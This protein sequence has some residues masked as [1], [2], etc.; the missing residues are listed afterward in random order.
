[1]LRKSFCL[2]LVAMTAGCTNAGVRN[3][4]DFATS[5]NELTKREVLF[6]LRKAYDEQATFVPSHVVVSQGKSTTSGS[7]SP[8]FT[9]PLGPGYSNTI[10]PSGNN[11]YTGVT[12]FGAGAFTI[13]GNATAS[14]DWT[15]T[16]ATDSDALMR[17]RTLYLYVAGLINSEDE[18]LCSYPVQRQPV[19]G[20]DEAGKGS[21][22]AYR[23]DCP[24]RPESILFYADPN[25]VTY[26]NCIVCITSVGLAARKHRVKD[27]AKPP[28]AEAEV[29]APDEVRAR[30]RVNDRLQRGIVFG[31]T[32]RGDVLGSEPRKK[33]QEG[34]TDLSRALTAAASAQDVIPELPLPQFSLQ[35]STRVYLKVGT[36]KYFAEFILLT[37]AAMA[38][39]TP[40][41]EK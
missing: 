11:Q 36:E 38:P 39:V 9:L 3:S 2:F 1:M 5:L 20:L 19:T 31:V 30:V 23:L 12:T 14:Q 16:P 25:F 32:Y 4:A 6:N 26:P 10:V 41:K 18:F 35:R 34:D 33:P 28:T 27:A 8:S 37:S 15:M 22:I 21:N 17:L 29:L 13:G 40:K 7:V 24:G